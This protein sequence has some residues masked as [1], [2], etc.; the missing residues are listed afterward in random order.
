MF[1]D[2][3][4]W[5]CYFVLV[6]LIF[7]VFLLVMFFVIIFFKMFFFNWVFCVDSFDCFFCFFVFFLIFFNKSWFCFNCYVFIF[8]FCFV[9]FGFWFFSWRWVK[10]KFFFLCMMWFGLNCL[11]VYMCFWV[12]MLLLGILNWN[13]FRLLWLGKMCVEWMMF[14][15]WYGLCVVLKF[16]R[17]LLRLLSLVLFFVMLFI[18]VIDGIME[19]FGC[20]LKLECVVVLRFFKLLIL[21]FLGVIWLFWIEFR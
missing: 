20:E 8:W 7:L 1:V 21:D 19:L 16:G 6:R 5:L 17:W 9:F 15:W 2:V 3:L 18:R 10:L 13:E 12:C 11:K 14:G 4:F